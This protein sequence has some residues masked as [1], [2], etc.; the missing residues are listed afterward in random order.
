MLSECKSLRSVTFG[1]LSKLERICAYAFYG[2]SI[3]SLSIPDNVVELYKKCFYVCKSLRSVTFGTLSKLERI[4]AEAFYG[5]SIE[6]FSIPDSVVELIS[7]ILLS[8]LSFSCQKERS[9]IADQARHC[10]SALVVADGNV[11]R[12]A[13]NTTNSQC[14]FNGVLCIS[15]NIPGFSVPGPFIDHDIVDLHIQ[16]DFGAADEEAFT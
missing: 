3:E 4:C 2:T 6:S 12:V 7:E 11:L 15:L 16:W 1:A 14:L 13:L 8:V 9:K 5:T 10:N